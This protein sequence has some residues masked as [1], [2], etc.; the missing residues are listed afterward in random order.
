MR[1]IPGIPDDMT[2]Q[3]CLSMPD[4]YQRRDQA[5]NNQWQ[6]PVLMSQGSDVLQKNKLP[7]AHMRDEVKGLVLGVA[8]D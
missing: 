2:V 4:M 1:R 5:C 6:D 3:C 7:G 8:V